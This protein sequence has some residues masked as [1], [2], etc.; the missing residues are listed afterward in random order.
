MVWC[1]SEPELPSRPLFFQLAVYCCVMLDQAVVAQQI[2]MLLRV[3]AVN[4]LGSATI[5]VV[6]PKTQHVEYNHAMQG[7]QGHEWRQNKDRKAQDENL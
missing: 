5:A 6:V 1:L 4:F 7:W 2:S 3:H